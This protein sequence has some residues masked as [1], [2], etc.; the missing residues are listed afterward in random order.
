MTDV[1]TYIQKQQY[2]FWLNIISDV[3]FHPDNDFSDDRLPIFSD[4]DRL[5]GLKLE[6]VDIVQE[7]TFFK[8]QKHAFIEI[9]SSEDYDLGSEIIIRLSIVK[10]KKD[11]LHLWLI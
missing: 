6:I 4:P 5:N 9:A 11:F 2:A 3:N 8:S 7:Y 10:N 1:L